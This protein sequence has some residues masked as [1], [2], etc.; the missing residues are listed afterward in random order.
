M[1][2]IDIATNRNGSNDYYSMHLIGSHGAA[3]AD[4]HENGHL[5]LGKAGMH[6]LIPPANEVM[7]LRNMLEEFVNGIRENRPWNVSPEDTLNALKTV[8]EEAD[9]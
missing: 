5:L 9:A 6:S 7:T 2:L 3:Y 4:D 8:S 1:S